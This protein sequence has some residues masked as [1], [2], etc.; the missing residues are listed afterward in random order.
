MK[1]QL[2]CYRRNLCKLSTSYKNSKNTDVRRPETVTVKGTEII[3]VPVKIKHVARDLTLIFGIHSEVGN[4]I[5][6]ARNGILDFS[7]KSRISKL[8]RN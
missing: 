7:A 3:P 1:H 2:R 8:L 6:N 4:E 5:Q